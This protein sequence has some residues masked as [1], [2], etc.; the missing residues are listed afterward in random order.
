MISSN[1]QKS[2]LF[3][4]EFLPT[5]SPNDFVS[6][7]KSTF[8]VSDEISS[9]KIDSI[10]PEFVGDIPRNHKKKRKLNRIISILKNYMLSILLHN[11]SEEK[12]FTFS[13]QCC[14]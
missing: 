4:F 11:Q 3:S 8:N 9:K 12:L 7:S 2:I 10:V 13:S 1:C 6:N 5:L 14:C